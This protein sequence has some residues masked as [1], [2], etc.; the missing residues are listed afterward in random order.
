[1]TNVIKKILTTINVLLLVIS[2]FLVLYINVYQFF[3]LGNNPF[4]Q[5]FFEFFSILLP[6]VLLI[7]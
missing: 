6:F 1:M 7:L 3:N 5:G 4:G 2:F